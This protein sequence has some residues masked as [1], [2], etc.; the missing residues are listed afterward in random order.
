[1]RKRI[2]VSLSCLL[3][4]FCAANASALEEDRRDFQRVVSFPAGRSFSVDHSLGNVAIYAQS[5]KAEADIRATIRCSADTATQARN[6]CDRIQISVQESA[7]GV[8]VRTQYP[9]DERGQNRGYRV[10][11]NITIPASAELDVRNRFGNVGVSNLLADAVINNSNGNVVFSGGRG[12]QRIENSF[13]NVVVQMNDGDVDVRNGNGNVTASQVTGRLDIANRFGNVRVTAA[14]GSLTINGN[15]ATVSAANVRGPA[16]IVNSFGAVTVTDAKDNVIVKN[17][18]GAVTATGVAGT[19]ELETSFNRVTF[20][21]IGKSVKV[22]ANNTQI[23]GDTVGEGAWIQTTF[24]SVDLR[25]VRGDAKAYG[26]NTSIRV[27]GIGGSVDAKTTFSGVSVADAEGRIAV[28]NEN[29]S[30]TV[31]AKPGQRCQPISLRTTF[32]PIR[33]TVPSGIGYNVTARTSFGRIRSEVDISG[34]VEW[35]SDSLTGRIGGGGCDL[36]LMGQN[37]NI[38]IFKRP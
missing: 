22:L 7:R 10:D 25:G 34:V 31:D 24:G 33:V 4:C 29:G 23:T 12:R 35:S 38:E 17:Q 1:M 3:I 27:T 19:A 20:S 16:S 8:E 32:G 5:S 21:R 18:N 28:E 30:V 9:P 14:N 26:N 15:N 36:R 6:L 11:Y 13:G 2:S 37:G